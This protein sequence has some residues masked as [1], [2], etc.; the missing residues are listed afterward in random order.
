MMKV[1]LK[2]KQKKTTSTKLC[3]LFIRG[4]AP[5]WVQKSFV[6]GKKNIHIKLRIWACVK[7]VKCGQ[8]AGKRNIMKT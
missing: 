7:F 1:H 6:I 3:T 8:V 5:G 2:K 4:P